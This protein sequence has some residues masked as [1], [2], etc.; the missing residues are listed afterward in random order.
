M[1]K[2]FKRFISIF[3]SIAIIATIIPFSVYASEE[4]V[5][6]ETE[7][8]VA[9]NA[10]IEY[11]VESLRTENSKTYVTAD[12]GYYQ[13]TSLMPIHQET[14]DQFEEI[15][16][17]NEDIVTVDDATSYVA[18]LAEA[19]AEDSYANTGLY[20][21][22]ALTMTGY[23]NATEYCVSG[24]RISDIEN[25]IYIRPSIISD[26]S[27][28][29]YSA[30]LELG[31]DYCGTKDNAIDMYELTEPIVPSKELQYNSDLLYDSI[32][33]DENET[34]VGDI[35]SYCHYC[36]LGKTPNY[37][38]ALTPYGSRT[39]V[40]ISSIVLGIYYRELGDVDNGIESETVDMD[41]AGTVY[42][43]NYSCSPVL[44][45]DDFSIYSELAQVN[46]QT[47]IN[48]SAIDDNASDGIGTRTNYYSTI[49]YGTNEYHWKSCNGDNIYFT[50]TTGNT[51]EGIDSSGEKYILTRED[52]ADVYAYNKIYVT[53]ESDGTVYRFGK[54]T[55]TG[56]ELGYLANI[57]DDYGN[58]IVISYSNGSSVGNEIQTITD[59]NNHT[60]KYNYTTLGNGTKQLSS[61]HVCYLTENEETLEE[62]LV[63]VKVNGE[64]IAI[65]YFYDDN[66]RMNKVVYPD[67]YSIVYTYDDNGQI[68][69]ITNYNDSNLS[70][71]LKS[72]EFTYDTSAGNTSK[73]LSY[74]VKNKDT[75]IENF[76]YS[77]EDSI[78][79]RLITDEITDNTKILKYDYSGNLIYCKEYSDSEYF[80]NYTD[81]NLE[82]II[83]PGAAEKN[84]VINGDFGQDLGDEWKISSVNGIDADSGDPFGTGVNRTYLTMDKNDNIAWAEQEITST[85]FTK[86]SSFIFS[87]DAGSTLMPPF[88]GDREFSAVVYYL[89]E[90]NNKVI[91]GKLGYDYAFIHDWQTSTVCFTLPEDVD[92]LYIKLTYNYFP[93][94][95]YFTGVKLYPATAENVIDVSDGSLTNE[96][97]LNYNDNGTIASETKSSTL[98]KT[99]G[100]YYDYDSNNYISAIT[101]D[102][103]KTYYNYDPSNGMLIS[104]GNNEESSDN[105][106]FAY[107]GI[108]ALTQV[109][110]TITNS[111]GDVSE[112][113]TSYTYEDDRIKTITH[114]GCTYEYEYT[115]YGKVSKIQ[116]LDGDDLDYGVEYAYLDKDHLGSIQYANGNM[117]VYTY[118]GDNI[119][120]IAYYSGNVDADNLLYEYTYQYDPNGKIMQYTDSANGTVTT[121][122]ENGYTISKDGEILYSNE[123]NQEVLFG[124][125]YT[126]LSGSH[127]S[128]LTNITTGTTDYTFTD[129]IPDT[130]ENGALTGTY[131]TETSEVEAITLNDSLGRT[132]GSSLTVKDNFKVN[133]VVTYVDT[134]SD[135]TT[136]LIESYSSSVSKSR[137]SIIPSYTDTRILRVTSYEYN[138]AGMITDIY[139]NSENNI[140]YST[141]KDITSKIKIHHYE[142]DEAG[143]IRL[144]V[145]TINNKAIKYTYDNGGNIT[146]KKIYTDGAFSYN[147]ATNEISFVES[148]AQE[149]VMTYKDSGMTDYLASYN[150]TA[151][152][153]DKAGNP[154]NYVGTNGFNT[155]EISGKFTWEGKRLKAF[156]S[157]EYKTTYQYDGDGR[158]TLKTRYDKENSLDYPT[159]TTEY[160]WEEDTLIGY[161]IIVNTFDEGTP[162]VIVDRTVRLIYN[163][164]NELMGLKVVAC[165]GPQYIS[166]NVYSFLRDGQGNI[167]D[168]YDSSETL[169]CSFT[170][171]AYGNVTPQMSGQAVKDF[172]DN[173]D[174]T[175]NVW[176]KIIAMFFLMIGLAGYTNGALV[177]SEE[178]YRGYIYD[179]ETGLYCTQNRYYS[180]AWG[181]FINADDPATL[182]DNIGEVTGTN[183]FTY[184]NNDPINETDPT[185][186]DSVSYTANMNILELLG[187]KDI[188]MTNIG[189]ST[190]KFLGEI[191]SKLDILA[192][193]LSSN[194]NVETKK[195][196]NRILGNIDN[197]V[198]QS[199][200]TDYIDHIVHKNQSGVTCYSVKKKNTPYRTYDSVDQ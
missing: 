163:N 22:Q 157:E 112:L 86:G 146:S 79:T 152:S 34:A 159:Q 199:H 104:K 91:I 189:M 35:T 83:I 85:D 195:Y 144:E 121:Y 77:D 151:I 18:A 28:F 61:I 123:S 43:N 36:S 65:N 2:N 127:T 137:A 88:T 97:T 153:Y 32:D 81:G 125:T 62:E 6:D 98:G 57:T 1:K 134:N 188:N 108:G 24:S 193:R 58:K 190:G 5:I 173:I 117:I 174:S 4:T 90:D 41:R 17:I 67:G 133:N 20:E 145:D 27:V 191:S 45:R 44:V 87:A 197:T 136:N 37:G 93:I 101:N 118:S 131:H 200:G 147:D 42:I 48:P 186:C 100:T 66:G 148:K 16:D 21:D 140:P 76:S 74:I 31:I 161:H 23:P 106:Q 47:V 176:I 11:E 111:E 46:I 53:K 51:Y 102:G 141:E 183:L 96:Y 84:Y 26:C 114:N 78:L 94:E 30:K 196:W 154:M 8:F 39:E 113:N 72:I 75:V 166:E 128:D 70:N 107:N 175:D 182:Q 40:E 135:K 60:Y 165:E 9:E 139:R 149:T 169:V 187:I 185:G 179:I 170:Y 29:I 167:T 164:N 54:H 7:Q 38:I 124:Q 184:C 180:P 194:T 122:S 63:N 109:K 110:Q 3:L 129:K 50:N 198:S 82:K 171:D 49:Q 99:M 19:S 95:G 10:E 71:K 142:Y 64:D 162:S 52:G 120:K 177:S 73:I 105:A 68:L 92:S 132:T 15:A 192:F 14:E 168:L 155:G 56:S 59:G 115:P 156:D 119:E 130:D 150:G 80:L 55:S 158:R 13:L 69:S 33:I 181:R 172:Y 160:I 138:D 89:D 12:G 116:V 103:R 126:V 25:V 178:A 143:Q